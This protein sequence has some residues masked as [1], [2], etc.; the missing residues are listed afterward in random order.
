MTGLEKILA[1]IEADA[2]TSAQAVL[3]Q[4]NKEVEQILKAAK[5]EV[6]DQCADMNK[7]SEVEITAKQKQIE[8]QAS[9]VK[10]KMI[11]E[12]KQA[13]INET[14]VKAQN[15]LMNLS[16]E[17]YFKNIESMIKKYAVPKAGKILFSPVDSKR[18]PVSYESRINA[19]LSDMEGAS[20]SIS[21]E[22]KNIDGGFIIQYGDIEINCSFHDLFSASRENIQD[23]VHQL[24]FE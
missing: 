24:L 10:R 12:A 15:L 3:T 17:E 19:I 16:D 2:K 1:Q 13:I 23:K 6:A 9:L 18:L 8:S 11:L 14:I 22:T 5:A 21:S 4:A 20:L 7:Q